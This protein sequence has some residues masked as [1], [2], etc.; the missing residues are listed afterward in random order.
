MPVK[1]M[2]RE[3]D[4]R[5]KLTG[6][7]RGIDRPISNHDKMCHMHGMSLARKFLWD[8]PFGHGLNSNA[9]FDSPNSGALNFPNRKQQMS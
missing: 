9:L 1:S 5:V 2:Q 7:A 4:A 6:D 3:R 8:S